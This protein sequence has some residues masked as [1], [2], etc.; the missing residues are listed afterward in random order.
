MQSISLILIVIFLILFASVKSINVKNNNRQNSLNSENQLEA[1]KTSDENSVAIITNVQLSEDILTL[2]D[3]QTITCNITDDSEIAFVY[4]TVW[5]E[6]NQEYFLMSNFIG[7]TYQLE[8]SSMR[9]ELGTYGNG[10]FNGFLLR[11]FFLK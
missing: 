10:N 2:R 6:S 9:A 1:P 4:L 8:W 5:F 7:D 11:I 3:T